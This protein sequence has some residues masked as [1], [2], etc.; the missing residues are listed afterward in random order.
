MK[1]LIIRN[2]KQNIYNLMLDEVTNVQR[3]SISNEIKT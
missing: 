2:R 1:N 3:S